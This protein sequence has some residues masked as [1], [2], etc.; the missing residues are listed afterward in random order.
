MARC[1]VCGGA[2]TC[3]RGRYLKVRPPMEGEVLWLRP[4]EDPGP[5]WVRTHTRKR[6]VCWVREVGFDGLRLQLV[7]SA[8]RGRIRAHYGAEGL[9]VGQC[10]FALFAQLADSAPETPAPEE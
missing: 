6:E 5:G 3:P 2:T 7:G 4:D 10:T 9:W 1:E 8:Q